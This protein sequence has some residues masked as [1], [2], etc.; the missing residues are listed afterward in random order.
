MSKITIHDGTINQSQ[1]GD[2]SQNMTI[3]AGATVETA[4]QNYA[5]VTNVRAEIDRELE[6]LRA[7]VEALAQQLTPKA[8]ERVKEDFEQLEKQAKAEEPRRRWFEVSAEGLVEAAKAVAGM[9]GPI[10]TSVAAIAKLL[11]V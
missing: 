9:A 2:V 3:G 1:V 4:T 5:P 11:F 8:A 6:T 7:A 10:S